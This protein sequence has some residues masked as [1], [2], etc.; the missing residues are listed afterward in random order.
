[1]NNETLQTPVEEPLKYWSGEQSGHVFI[2]E[3]DAGMRESL[4]R[5][6]FSQ[7]HRVYAFAEP[8]AFLHEVW[9]IYPSV[10]LLDMRLPALSGVEVQARLVEMGMDIPIVF[11]SGESTVQQAVHAIERGAAQFLVKPVSRA[12]LL[13]AVHKGL[14][15]DAERQALRLRSNQRKARLE[16]LAPRE[17]EVLELLLEGHG[18]QEVSARM[19]ISYATAK[20]YK[21]N[22]LIKLGV[23]NMAE[24]M[25]LMRAA[26]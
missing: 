17:R 3:D 9:R 19:H 5:T 8:L 4:Q 7:G 2:V 25:E 1:M 18:N 13:G 6:I 16:R 26:G 23:R 21:G 10:L 24:L 20:Q 22:V 11:V 14:Q 12:E 15:L